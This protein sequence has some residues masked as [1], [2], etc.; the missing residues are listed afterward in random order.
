MLRVRKSC[1]S[2]EIK[3]RGLTYV[4][5]HFISVY[6]ISKFRSNTSKECKI[7]YVIRTLFFDIWFKRV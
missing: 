6:Q 1:W 7:K 2:Q 3:S 4:I 5:N